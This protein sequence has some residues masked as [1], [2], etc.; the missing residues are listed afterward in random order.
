MK[1]YYTKHPL[2]SERI[3]AEDAEVYLVSEVEKE[4]KKT[5]IVAMLDCSAGNETVGEMW[6][7]T[8]IFEM[9]AP[10]GNVISW[11]AKASYN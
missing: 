7:E 6:V 10:L 9:G 5:Q 4:S 11:A 1:K 2:L 8:K 3:S